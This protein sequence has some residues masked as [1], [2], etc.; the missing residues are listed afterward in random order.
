[1]SCERTRG[2]HPRQ[3][4]QR[5]RSPTSKGSGSRVLAI[6]KRYCVHS[7]TVIPFATMAIVLA[8]VAVLLAAV[9]VVSLTQAT[10][11][12]GLIAGAFFLGIMARVA[13][14]RDYEH[15]R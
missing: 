4:R 6:R 15:R 11:G 14:A 9:G 13:Q 8:L 12:V 1:M 2:C 10:T 5:T 3:W 7:V